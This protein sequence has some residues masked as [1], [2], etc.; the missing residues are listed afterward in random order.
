MLITLLKANI[1]S[2]ENGHNIQMQHHKLTY[3]YLYT[4][5]YAANYE[6]LNVK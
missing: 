4:V 6:E 2:A 5:Y 3:A 1:L